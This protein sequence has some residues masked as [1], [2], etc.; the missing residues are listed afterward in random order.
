MSSPKARFLLVVVPLLVAGPAPAAVCVFYPSQGAAQTLSFGV[1]EVRADAAPGTIL[2]EKPT[3]AW[4]SKDFNCLKPRR[5]ASLGIFTTPSAW[6]NGVYDTNVPGV[7]IRMYYV[8]NFG[9]TPVPHDVHVPSVFNGKLI[10]AHFRVQLVKT[11]PV[12]NG[13]SLNTGMLAQWGYDGRRQVWVDL[14]DARVEPQRSTC[15]FAARHLT[16]A[17]DNVDGGTLAA[18]G[19]SRWATQQLVATGCVN[20]TQILMTFS[21]PADET[22]TTLFKLSGAD[23]ARGVGVELRSDDPDAQAIPNSATPLVLA[24]AREGRSYGFRARY[25]TTGKPLGPGPAHTSI[26]VNVT[27]R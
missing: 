18:A 8:G 13:G 10:N 22:D 24:A 6:G 14:L 12:E 20:A 3:T 15:A 1:I 26:T 5:V 27:Y 23:A 7:G 9:D 25:R 19:S 4:T 21:A 11:G 17:L 16:F 2:A